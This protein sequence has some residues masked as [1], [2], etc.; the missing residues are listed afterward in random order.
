MKYLK[1]LFLVVFVASA[2]FSC[3][4]QR[5]CLRRF[6]PALD[7]LI[8]VQTN[9]STVYRDTVVYR[10]LLGE[11]RI[12][13]VP[14]PCP[15]PPVAYIP[16]TARAET[17]LAVAKAYWD[18]PSIKLILEQRDSMLAFKLDSVKREYF[19]ERVVTETITQVHE[20]KYIPGFWKACTYILIGAVLFGLMALMIKIFK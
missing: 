4:T 19:S 9:D 7:T 17:S 3:T 12:D 11:V 1:I 13:S 6:P 20:V 8:T 5:K 15:P 10:Y 14:I 16:D 18:Y 2:G